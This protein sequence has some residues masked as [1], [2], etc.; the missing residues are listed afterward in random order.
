MKGLFVKDMLILANQKKTLLMILILGLAMSMTM[1]ATAI[2]SYIIVLGGMLALGT[3]A[4]DEI[5]NGYSFIFTLPVSRKTYVREKYLF[6]LSCVLISMLVG[7]ALCCLLLAA[8]LGKAENGWMSIPEMAFPM[9]CVMLLLIAGTI[10]MRIK[11]GSEKGRIVLYIFAGAFMLI[12]AAALKF[13]EPLGRTFGPMFMS[14]KPVTAIAAALA[15]SVLFVVISE[16]I[17][18]RIIAKKEF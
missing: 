2:I 6:V 18:Q 7:S 14:V 13:K 3:I 10:P 11:Y 17:T 12:G 8:G 5:D 4:Y 1:Q 16:R 9:L 15:V